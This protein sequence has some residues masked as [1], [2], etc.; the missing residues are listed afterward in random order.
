MTLTGTLAQINT[1]LAAA[2]AVIYT[3]NANFNGADTL[4]MTTNDGGDTG[5]DPSTSATGNAARPASRTP[6]RSRSPS[7]RSTTG[8]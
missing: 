4:T 1:T 6:T 2:G 7:T 5:V 3:G 8:R